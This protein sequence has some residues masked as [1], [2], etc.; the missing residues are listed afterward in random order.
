M[1]GVM[2]VMQPCFASRAVRRL[3][4]AI[5]AT[6]VGLTSC[7]DATDVELLR[8]DATGVLFGQAFLDLDGDGGLA[9]SDSP[10]A[11]VTVVLV[12]SASGEAI[13]EATTEA[14]GSF[15]LRDVPVGT[16]TLGIDGE[17]LGDSLIAV[18]SGAGTVTV[19]LG[20][21]AQVNLGA[22]YPVLSLDEVRD[23]E[24]GRRVFTSGIALN[25]RLNPDPAGQVHFQSAAS[26]LRALDVE[27]G[28]LSVG[29]SVRLLGRTAIEDG[30]PVLS[31]VTPFVLVQLA[32]VPVRVES[33]TDEAASAGGGPLDAALVRIQRAEISD[34]AT[35]NGD[36][37]FTADDGTGPVEVVLR[38]FLGINP[39]PLRPDTIVRI[40][41]A[42]GLLTPHVD[43]TG[44]LRWRLLPRAGSDVTVETKLADVGVAVAFDP[45]QAVQD[46]VVEIQVV[47]SNAGPVTAT[48]VAVADTIP[49]E[50]TL[51]S[52][53]ATAGSYD[54][55]EGLWTVGEI[56]PGAAETLTIRVEVTTGT[57]GVIQNRAFRLPLVLEVD[58]NG[59]NNAAAA[60][61]TIP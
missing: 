39:S 53:D 26:Y 31:L 45:D 21:T 43:G 37:H 57:P 54:E 10:L 2:R 34:T 47:V 17:V 36:F 18:G 8:I 61:L 14:D 35:V 4:I 30:Q 9:A 22:S 23:A 55:V 48:S 3:A 51:V 11:A 1:M 20:D 29:D 27:R 6:G 40:Q 19:E 38:Q 5:L 24:P 49:A 28:S 33:S 25:A 13:R 15:I 44:T 52:V 50:L 12:A 46:D 7:I 41:Q 16:Y 58:Q 56:A 59:A 42:T 32:T 60:T